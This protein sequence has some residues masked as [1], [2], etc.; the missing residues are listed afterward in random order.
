[1]SFIVFFSSNF[2]YL[3][4]NKKKDLKLNKISMT[5]NLDY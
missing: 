5:T 3:K 4:P 2:N 1:M